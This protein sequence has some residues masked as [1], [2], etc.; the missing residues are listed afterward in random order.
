M[1][2]LTTRNEIIETKKII[3]SELSKLQKAYY[4]QETF[5]FYKEDNEEHLYTEMFDCL[6]N[7]IIEYKTYNKIIGLRHSNLDTFTLTLTE[8]LTELFQTI[9]A[10]DFIIIS[11]LKCDFFGNRENKFKPLK[12]SYKK[13]EKI[14]GNKTFKEAFTFDIESLSDFIEIL[15]W[16]TRC[17]SSLAEYIFLFDKNEQIQIKLCKYGNIHLTEFNIEQLP[18]KKL[19][20][21]GWT[22]IDGE[23]FDNFSSDSK[24]QG[25]QIKI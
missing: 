11:H 19:N 10:K 14:V 22:I 17:D 1:T 23:E 15:F 25:R 4:D 16:T 3:G 5:Q 13:L 8:K 9:S 6:A 20:T 7:E 12:N 21:L 2:T 18:N 24:I